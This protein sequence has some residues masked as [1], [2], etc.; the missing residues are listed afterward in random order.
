[1]ETTWENQGQ[2]QPEQSRTIKTW[3][4]EIRSRAIWHYGE[5]GFAIRL[6]EF[7]ANL[8]AS[9]QEAALNILVK[10]TDP[11]AMQLA[12]VWLDGAGYSAVTLEQLYQQIYRLRHDNDPT[13]HS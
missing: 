1:M 13:S 3:A 8:A 12:V 6:L 7:D 9:K 10:A 2:H 4:D 11:V 5:K